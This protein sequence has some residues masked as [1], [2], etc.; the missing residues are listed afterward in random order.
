[1]V[2]LYWLLQKYYSE[3]KTSQVE[4]K[5]TYKGFNYWVR[6]VIFSYTKKELPKSRIE[7]LENNF[8]DWSWNPI[9]DQW[10]HKFNV[11]VKYY[12][13]FKTTNIKEGT[14]YENINLSNFFNGE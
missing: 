14:I 4:A 12:K 7:F 5:K 3:F 10:K 1:M 6:K 9:E 11:L 13:D 8:K 2:F